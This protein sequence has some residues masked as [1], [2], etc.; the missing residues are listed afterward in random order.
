MRIAI[1]DDIKEFREQIKSSI[2]SYNAMFEIVEYSNGSQLVQS[3]EQ[4]DLIFLDIEMPEM[5]GMTVARKLREQ[6][7]EVPIV[8]LTSHEELVYNAFEVKAF[9]F[10]RKPV[11]R[12]ELSRTLQALEQ[13]ITRTEMIMITQKGKL[14]EIP[15]RTVLYLEAYGDGTYIYDIFGNVYES[16][17]QLKVWESKLQ[18]KYFYRIHKSLIVALEHVKG[19]ENDIVKL[20]EKEVSLKIARR[21]VGEFKKSYLEYIDKNAK[22]I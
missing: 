15:L 22:V 6:K 14:R 5:D 2:N 16:L 3:K 8:F 1:C 17:E 18:D 12:K 10:L 20:G 21:S 13:E 19:V 7:N 4:Y 9:R 11:D